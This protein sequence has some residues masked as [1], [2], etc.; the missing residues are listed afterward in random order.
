MTVC[1]CV[2]DIVKE[3]RFTNKK[4]STSR[5]NHQGYRTHSIDSIYTSIQYTHADTH[6]NSM[7]KMI[8]KSSQIFFFDVISRLFR[9]NEN[10]GWLIKIGFAWIL[11]IQTC[12]VSFY[13]T[14]F[15]SVFKSSWIL[16]IEIL[17]EVQTLCK[18]YL[19]EFSMTFTRYPISFSTVK[20]ALLISR[21][22]EID[23]R[24]LRQSIRCFC[25]LYSNDSN[26][27]SIL[28]YH[29]LYRNYWIDL[30]WLLKFDLKFI[31]HPKHAKLRFE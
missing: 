25:H 29:N 4:S 22:I 27:H 21:S 5:T 1:V 15:L 28:Q 19:I 16:L 13:D 24:L 26:F 20:M 3:E 11:T 7:V 14:L 12:I 9:E 18:E 8:M 17:D 31:I 2:C 10:I 30:N 6:I 23:V